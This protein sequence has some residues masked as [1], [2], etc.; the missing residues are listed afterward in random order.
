M[1][2]K[3]LLR[4][5][6]G[7]SRVDRSECALV[8]R[9]RS[10][11]PG[12]G[13][14]AARSAARSESPADRRPGRSPPLAGGREDRRRGR[15]STASATRRSAWPTWRSSP[16]SPTSPKQASGAPAGI[17]ERLAA[18]RG[19]D[20]Q[21]DRE[22]GA[23]L[24]DPDAA[25]DVDEHVGAGQRRPAVA[26][27]HRE[28]HRQP[29][30]VDPVGDPARRDDLGRRDERLDLDQQRPRA[31]HR[32]ED[33]RA[34]RGARLADEARRGSATSTRPPERISKTPT[35][36]VAPKRFL[37]ARRV[38]KLRSRSPSKS[39]TQSTRCSSTR[40]PATA[41]SLV[42]WPTRITAQS[43]RF[44]A[45][46]TAL[47]ASRTCPTE[48]GAPVIPSACSV[49]I[50]SITQAA[51]RSASSVARTAS[52]EVSASAGTASAASPR[53]SARSRTCAAD[54]SPET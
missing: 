15:T 21:R 12:R 33:D 51:G 35:S 17:G 22:V 29:V 26:G 6:R 4:Q 5:R 39:S 9:P 16:V 18:M 13:R 46:I 2:A 11:A 1:M 37:S 41:P 28:H 47:A 3:A 32:A 43:I 8:K 38:R 53:R 25:G 49:W 19:G 7:E 54:S 24:V 27:E 34:R 23:G 40:G 14:A 42:T 20:R 30:A 48:P 10:P 50:E 52:S 31:L 44:A 45:S 36:L